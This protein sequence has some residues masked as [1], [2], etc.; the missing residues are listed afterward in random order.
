M[1]LFTVAAT[2]LFCFHFQAFT[3]EFVIKGK[4]TNP[5]DRTVGINIIG[6][7][8]AYEHLDIALD[9]L[10]NTFEY[11]R[12]LKDITYIDF[13]HASFANNNY[14]GIGLNDLII[15]PGDEVMISFDTKDVWNTLKFEGKSAE[16]FRYHT[17]DYLETH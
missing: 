6:R 3:Q 5:I 16:K 7:A 17:E 1:K 12:Q 11:R 2:I 13:I 15:E 8:D 14:T 4:I 10:N 9:S